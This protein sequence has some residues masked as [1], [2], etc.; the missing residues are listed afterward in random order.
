MLSEGFVTSSSGDVVTN[1][2]NNPIETAALADQQHRADQLQ[3]AITVLQKLVSQYPDDPSLRQALDAIKSDFSAGNYTAAAVHQAY[4]QVS[5]NEKAAT[6][7][8]AEE[9]EEEARAVTEDTRQEEIPAETASFMSMN[10]SL[11]STPQQNQFRLGD[12]PPP[13][14]SPYALTHDSFGNPVKLGT[15]SLYSDIRLGDLGVTSSEP[16]LLNTGL[17]LKPLDEDLTNR[18]QRIR[19]ELAGK[20]TLESTNSD[21]TVSAQT[22]A[23]A[24]QVTPVS[25]L[26]PTR[27]S[28]GDEVSNDNIFGLA[29]SSGGI[30]LGTSSSGLRLGQ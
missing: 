10:E 30:K 13:P 24:R 21:P 18:I 26:E 27:I 22:P 1:G 23:A 16:S 6:E 19:D 3:K 11:A 5:N 12:L 29:A 7:E 15:T 9:K 17:E 20:A 14:T 8:V 25:A 28:G 2:D 4:L